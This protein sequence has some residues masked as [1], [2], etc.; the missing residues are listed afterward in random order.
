MAHRMDTEDRDLLMIPGPVSVEDD[1]LAALARPIRPHYG[2]DWV[3]LY[4]GLCSRLARIFQTR[5]E[6]HLLFGPGSAAMEMALGSVLGPG[7]EVLVAVNGFFGERIARVARALQLEV[8]RVEAPLGRPVDADQVEAALSQHPRVRAV[9]LVHHE[10]MTGVL[11][12]VAEVAG[13]AG[14]RGA[15]AVVDAVSSLGGT[16]LDMD[17]WGL[18][19]CVSVANKCLGGPVGVAPIACSERAREAMDDGR[20]KS[21]G[22]YLNLA[23]WRRYREKWGPWHPHPT[24][25]PVSAIQALSV[26]VD[27]ILEMGLEE[28]L[29]RHQRASSRLRAGLRQLGFELLVEDEHASPVTTAVASRPGMRVSHYIDWLQQRHGLRVAGGLGEL[30]GRSFRVGTMGRAI[31]PEVV[32]RYLA[33]TREYLEREFGLAP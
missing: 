4:E 16:Q 21:A 1:V 3:A 24:T 12:P 19:L 9:A 8:L 28:H 27:R 26:A 11:N 17:S 14:A 25:M 10:T 18:D 30:A 7:E 15:L 32:D 31:Q 33:A 2:K 23:T 6:V 5:S 13:R 29:A 20:P 22:W